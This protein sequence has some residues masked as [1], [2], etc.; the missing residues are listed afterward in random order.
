MGEDRA[1]QGARTAEMRSLWPGERRGD[2]FLRCLRDGAG[3]YGSAAEPRSHAKAER[4]HMTVVLCDMVDSTSLAEL[5]DPEDFR[6]VLSA[7]QGV[8]AGAIERFSGSPPSGWVTACSPT[9]AIHAHTRTTHCA[10]STRASASLPASRSS[11]IACGSATASSCRCASDPQRNR[12]GR[13]DGRR[14][15]P[16]S[17]RDRG[18]DTARRRAPADGGAAGVDRRQRRH[19][20]LLGEGSTTE[21]SGS[22]R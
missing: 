11:T 18:R 22:E 16:G 1:N 2:A 4:R 21:P 14:R 10:R 13:G 17:A 20:G 19:Q 6:E 15:H 5:L 12:C 3:R 8:C 9:S 7:Y